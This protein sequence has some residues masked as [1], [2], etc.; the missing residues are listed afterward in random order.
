MTHF[1]VLSFCHTAGDV[2]LVLPYGVA[3][4]CLLMALVPGESAS[5]AVSGLRAKAIWLLSL[6]RATNS[7]INLLGSVVSA[8]RATL[9]D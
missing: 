7:Q 5:R 2:N 1:V 3:C 4:P 9:E 6:R 8:Q